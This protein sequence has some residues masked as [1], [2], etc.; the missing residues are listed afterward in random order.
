MSKTIKV[1]LYCDEIKDTSIVDSG[2][3]YQ[4]W[5]YMGL[6]IVPTSLENQLVKILCDYRCGNPH[7]HIGWETC[8]KICYYHAK[9]NREIHYTECKSADVY[10][11]A[12]RWVN[13]ASK[14]GIYTYFYILGINLTNLDF[15]CFGH[16]NPSERFN[17]IYNR[18]FRTAI[19]KSVK[20]YFYQYDKIIIENIFH[21]DGNITNHY[22][23]P[24]HSI[25]KLRNEDA[26]ISFLTDK[27]D[28]LDSNHNNTRNARSHLIQYI[29]IIM[30]AVFNALHWESKN[31][32]KE[33]I[34]L[35]IYPLLQRMM[36]F[37]GNKNSSYNN[38]NQKCIDFFPSR[39]LYGDSGISINGSFYKNRE[40]LIN[41]KSQPQLF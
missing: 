22:Y 8:D 36:R 19:L 26:K 16:H 32:K 6:L 10:H 23:F 30:G 33:K 31:E 35:A 17:T 7:N 40:I 37:P 9:N 14:D 1:N 41:R 25:Y 38:Y 13:F 24:W 11:I 2:S 3:N 20:S 28:F 5:I 39:R 21:D 29:D 4:H 12:K 34:A 18:F 27:I 15:S